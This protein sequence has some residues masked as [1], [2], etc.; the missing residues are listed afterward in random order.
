MSIWKI[1]GVKCWKLKKDIQ[2]F[3]CPS[4]GQERHSMD[5]GAG[6]CMEFFS[7]DGRRKISIK[8]TSHNRVL[9]AAETPR[10]KDHSLNAG[11]PRAAGIFSV[12]IGH[13]RL[14][15]SLLLSLYGFQPAWKLYFLTKEVPYP[16]K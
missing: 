7:A 16:K 5:G 10:E 12:T 2:R 13:F 14:V 3:V 6:W 4:P 8:R 15:T 11:S 9:G 1:I